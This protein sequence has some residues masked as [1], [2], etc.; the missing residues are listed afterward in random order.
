MKLVMVAN[1]V[2]SCHAWLSGFPRG[3]AGGASSVTQRAKPAKVTTA[4][5]AAT[6]A[7]QP[8]VTV[9]PMTPGGAPAGGSTTMPLPIQPP[10]AQNN[11][12]QPQPATPKK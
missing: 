12:V 2:R 4:A 6:P 3:T 8:T 11:Q 9:T 1:A 10:P 5:P 7:K